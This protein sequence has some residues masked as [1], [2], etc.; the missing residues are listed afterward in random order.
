VKRAQEEALARQ[1]LESL[2]VLAGGIAHDF[3]NL[4]GG[5][6]AETEFMEMDLSSHSGLIDELHRIKA[7]ATRGAEIVRELMIYAGQNEAGSVERVDVSRLVA[8]M[9]ELLKVSIS[10]HAVLTTNFQKNLPPVWGSAA[11]IR[12][13]VMNLIINASEAIGETEG[14]INVTTEPSAGE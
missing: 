8:E 4:L 11:Q 13:V 7:S 9:L 5:I 10:K 14:V 6:L 2:G 1:K 3:N 12:Q